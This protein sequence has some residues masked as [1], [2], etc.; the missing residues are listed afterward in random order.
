[1][2]EDIDRVKVGGPHVVSEVI[3]GEAIIIDLNSGSY[4]SLQGTGAEIWT[5]VQECLSVRAILDHLQTKYAAA[6]EVIRETT[7]AL[8]EQ[9]EAEAL[10]TLD[11]TAPEDPACAPNAV[12][13]PPERLPFSPPELRTYTDMQ[14]LLLLDPIHEV[15]ASGWPKMPDAESGHSE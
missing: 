9:L 4:Y 5:G 2:I 7:T 11:R 6:D 3:D 10:I 12:E 8:L 1:V 13:T 14:E 15:D